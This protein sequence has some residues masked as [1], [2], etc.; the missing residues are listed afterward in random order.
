MVSTEVVMV[1]ERIVS[2]P[3]ASPVAGRAAME[4]WQRE[5]PAAPAIGGEASLALTS[6][7][8]DSPSRG[9]PLLFILDD[10]AESQEQ[11]SLDIGVGFA[12]EAINNAMG[13][14]RDVIIP[15]T[16]YCSVMFLPILLLYFLPMS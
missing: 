14:L 6:V 1:E 2:A 13:V 8:G 3:L 16:K 15:S 10:A 4:A 9:E 5:G 12:L 7:G 11:E